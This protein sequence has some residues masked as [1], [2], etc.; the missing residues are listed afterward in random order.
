VVVR[1]QVSVGVD[2]HARPDDAGGLVDTLDASRSGAERVGAKQFGR[3][4]RGHRR[5][6]R[7]DAGREP[8]GQFLELVL[9]P[10][11]LTVLL[12]EMANDEAGGAYSAD[13]VGGM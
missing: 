9:Q 11:R 1:E 6:D 12:G 7:D 13:V 3:L 5:G 2:D 8:F 10:A 4:G